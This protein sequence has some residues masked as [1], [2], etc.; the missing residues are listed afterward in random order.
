[1]DNAED[2]LETLNRLQDEIQSLQST[3]STLLLQLE[4][5]DVSL[6]LSKAKYGTA[7]NRIARI[8]TLPNEI[9]AK[10]FE[11]GRDS[12]IPG[13]E[14]FEILASHI[15]TVWRE[16]AINTPSLWSI[17]EIAPHK[18]AQ[19]LATYVARAKACSLH[20]RFNFQEEVWVPDRCV[21]E[22][23]LSSVERWRSLEILVYNEVA[24][25]T[26]LAHLERLQASLLEEITIAR[27]T[28]LNK[29][30]ISG[31][32][33]SGR[34]FHGGAPRLQKLHLESYLMSWPPLDH[35]TTL[36]L[37]ELRRSTRPTWNRFRELLISLPQLSRLSIHGDV[38]SSKLPSNFEIII[39]CLR[40]LRIR[41]TTLLGNR[42]SD[43]LIAISAPNLTSL[44]LYDIVDGDLDPWSSGFHLLQSVTSLTLYWPNFT[45]ATYLKLFE[46]VPSVTHLTLMDRQPTDLLG[47]LSHPLSGSLDFPW[48]EIADFALY[49][50]NPGR[51]TVGNMI[52]ARAEHVPLRRLRM[53]TGPPMPLPGVQAL[54]FGLPAQWPVWPEQL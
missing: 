32:R 39:S 48:P 43:I 8:G 27:Q 31:I 11:S 45:T 7:K 23:I 24:L 5:I 29:R 26:T 3:K 40:S 28:H 12:N 47:L 42:A 6:S 4:S 51:G 13:G 25:Y 18:S 20:L 53:G 44:T 35:L 14:R 9:L 52:N 16:V 38:V 33:N 21:W 54:P 1:M 30:F 17:L 10:I 46:T 41:G 15:T 22:L 49:P 37:H 34:F 2:I 50:G 19:M 36:Y